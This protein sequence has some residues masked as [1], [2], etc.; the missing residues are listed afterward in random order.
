MAKK[1]KKKTPDVFDT[2]FSDYRTDNVGLAVLLTRMRK[3]G[4]PVKEEPINFLRKGGEARFERYRNWDADGIGLSAYSVEGYNI[5]PTKE[6]WK[7]VKKVTVKEDPNK[8]LQQELIQ[9]EGDAALSFSTPD[10]F[11]QVRRDFA[12]QLLERGL[13]IK[14]YHIGYKPHTDDLGNILFSDEGKPF[15]VVIAKRIA[16]DI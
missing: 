6:G 3:E 10:E 9:P 13:D 16:Y 8:Y 5:L 14:D 15:N 4:V 7:A 2:S 1:R 12:Y 11:K